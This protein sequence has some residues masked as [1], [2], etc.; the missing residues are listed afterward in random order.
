MKKTAVYLSASLLLLVA[1]C[2]WGCDSRPGDSA[3]SARYVEEIEEWK[4]YR[5]KR[6]TSKSGY[7]SLTGL[8]WI[9][10]GS[11]SFGSALSN[12]LVFPGEGIPPRMGV[13]DLASGVATI[14]AEAGVEIAYEGEPVTRMRL[15][16]DSHEDGATKLTWDRLTW[17]LVKRGDRFGIRLSD[18]QAPA[19]KHFKG[20]ERYSTSEDWRVVGRFEP[21]K[22]MK[23]LEIV[24]VN[25]IVSRELCPGALVFEWKGTEYRLEGVPSGSMESYFVVFGDATNG[26][27]TYGAGRFLYV[28]ASD[29]NGR[30]IIDF[31]KAYTPWCAYTDFTTCQLPPKQNRLPIEV[32][33]G[34]KD[35]KHKNY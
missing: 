13:I 2:F 23:T 32:T 33:A 28:D 14:T 22:P 3:T 8:F 9:E 12:D 11:H 7:L 25:G 24:D 5:I 15:R 21:Y 18:P 16:P 31:N 26:H 20:V 19:L 27:E 29:E 1:V 35:Y 4:A 17:W 6:L 10:D 34:E 30:V